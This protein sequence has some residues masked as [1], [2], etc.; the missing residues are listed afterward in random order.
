MVNAESGVRVGEG[1]AVGAPVC[2]EDAVVALER[3]VGEAGTGMATAERHLGE[4]VAVGARLP[5]MGL[6]ALVVMSTGGV[7]IGA[8][9]AACGAGGCEVGG[10]G[11]V[12]GHGGPPPSDG[13]L[14]PG[15]GGDMLGQMG[16]VLDELNS[17]TENQ[18]AA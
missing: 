7:V 3:A 6:E 17:V 11:A 5:V 8:G 2:I 13:D 10:G 1:S 9:G 16:H 15:C 14:R 4:V 12:M 18:T